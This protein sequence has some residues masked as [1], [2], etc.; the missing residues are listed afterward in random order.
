MLTGDPCDSASPFTEDDTYGL[1]TRV[2]PYNVVGGWLG[3]A[4]AYMDLTN[5]GFVNE[6]S[7]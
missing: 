3:Y 7:K 1:C 4:R 2:I 5:S 6:V